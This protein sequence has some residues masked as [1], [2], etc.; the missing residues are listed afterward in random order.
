MRKDIFFLVFSFLVLIPAAVFELLGL[1]ILSSL[2]LL[3]ASIY[4]GFYITDNKN[5]GKTPE[6]PLRN[7]RKRRAA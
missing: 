4:N 2:T 7:N 3:M 1:A 5:E 6:K